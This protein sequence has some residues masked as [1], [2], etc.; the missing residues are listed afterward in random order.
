MSLHIHIEYICLDEIC[1]ES[2][3]ILSLTSS[4]FQLNFEFLHLI[5]II[6]EIEV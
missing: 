4:R 6:P 5:Q 2:D 1:V 3:Q